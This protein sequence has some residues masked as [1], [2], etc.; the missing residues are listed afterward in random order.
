MRII[1]SHWRRARDTQG[2]QMKPAAASIEKPLTV[3][4]NG[5][6][7]ELPAAATVSVL[8]EQLELPADRV[9]V[10]MDREIVRRADWERTEIPPGASFE[11][12]HFVGGG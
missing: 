1:E 7:V 9:A 2:A 6:S 10:E 11:V 12:V 4:V 5:E 8:L 3:R